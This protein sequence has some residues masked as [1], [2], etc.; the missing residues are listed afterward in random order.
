MTAPLR[1]GFATPP[2]HRWFAAPRAGTDVCLAI[3]LMGA[4]CAPNTSPATVEGVLRLHGKP[5]DDCLVTFLPE[6]RPGVGSSHA[7]G[8][9]DRHGHF[10][11]RDA[12]QHDG[13]VVGWHR[14]TVE[15]LLVSQGVHRR[16]HGT[17][18][19]DATETAS[20][21]TRH[22]RVPPEYASLTRTPLRR[23]VKPGQQ[24]IDLNLP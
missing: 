20:P 12:E 14:V 16:D 17:L 4:G 3:L 15:D 21:P 1:L 5:L 2:A 9:T 23:E 8:V 24:L 6:P 13:A 18:D 11:L 22:S 7:V 10:R 19:A